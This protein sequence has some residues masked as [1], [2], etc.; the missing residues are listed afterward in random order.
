MKTKALSKQKYQ[1]SQGGLIAVIQLVK[2]GSNWSYRTK[3]QRLT[4]T[5]TPDI[6]QALQIAG[7]KVFSNPTP[8]R[9]V[10]SNSP[11]MEILIQRLENAAKLGD[12]EGP[13]GNPISLSYV[14][15]IRFAL[16]RIFDGPNLSKHK[17][18]EFAR[19]E[20]GFPAPVADY[21]RRVFAA[22]GKLLTEGQDFNKAGNSYN[23]TIRHLK[24]L[25]KPEYEETIFE[26]LTLCPLSI[27]AIRAL[28]KKR[29]ERAGFKSMPDI[30]K[31]FLDN[32]FGDRWNL[33]G[34]T[35]SARHNV[36]S[37]YW[38]ARCCGLRKSE[39]MNARHDW[40]EVNASGQSLIRVGHTSPYRNEC[41]SWESWSPKNRK[42]RAI[43]IPE[44]LR[45][46]LQGERKTARPD[47]PLL[48]FIGHDQER[49]SFEKQWVK[50]WREAITKAGY[51]YRD[52]PKTTHHLRGEYIT[53]VCH[54]TG[55]I[56]TAGAYAG[57]A[58]PST[59]TAHYYD[60]TQVQGFVLV[61]PRRSADVPGQA[62][63]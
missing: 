50:N 2:R 30:L 59:T 60:P 56:T 8:G 36:F 4:S 45:D 20:N 17:L 22:N 25:F 43:P 49:S 41:A 3:G 32:W 46:Y 47:E 13:N 44:W 15:G 24:A 58:D 57:H 61:D 37:R 21:R 12:V 52:F 14:K 51:D 48:D 31:N 11:T 10:A 29:V 33:S 54:K 6:D 19:K 18:V 27:A 7:Q 38:L 63:A 5:G 42:S 39:I 40:L 53:E 9:Q 26:G 23:N 55:G 62:L 1:L 34:S 16:Q 28:R 35:S